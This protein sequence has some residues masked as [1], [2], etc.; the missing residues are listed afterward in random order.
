MRRFAWIAVAGWLLT[1]VACGSGGQK[2]TAKTGAAGAAAL[3]GT[4]TKSY[5]PPLPPDKKV[6][7]RFEDYNL[8]SAGIGRDATLKMLDEFQQKFPNIKVETKATPSDQMFPSIQAQI[9][10]ND[11]P[12]IA[13]LLLREW[14]QN[15]EF[16]HPQVLTDIVPPAEFQA[17]VQGEYPLNPR[18][19]KLTERDGKLQGVAYVFSTP[20]L[21]YNADVFRQAGLDPDKP[22]Q[23]WEE[24]KQAAEQI[25]Q[26]SGNDGVFIACI[27]NDWCTQGLLYSAGARVM[28][29]ARSRITF[30]D[31]PAVAWY[32]FWQSMVQSGAHPDMSENDALTAFQ[33]GKLGM[34]LQTSAVQG[35]LLSAAKGKF[36]VRSTGQPS[37]AGHQVIPVNSGSALAILTTNPDKQRAAWELMKFLTSE[38]AFTIITSEIGYLPLRTGILDDDRYLKNWPNRQL[39]LPNVQ[40]MENLES[41]Y[42]YP[43]QN[44]LQIRKLFLTGLSEVLFQGKDPAKTMADYQERAQALMPHH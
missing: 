16:V 9:A 42:S 43:G 37:F 40:Q 11:P 15:V 34:Y 7:I 27:E 30:G 26:R 31:A 4:P 22:P 10:A 6:T 33:A 35:S 24:V 18:G 2:P 39:I 21:F 8:A 41:T 12:D 1:V 23:S 44:N 32:R 29:E 14:D 36:E 3:A 13:Q 20:T 38:H 25:K 17:Y 28:D 5:P 19:L